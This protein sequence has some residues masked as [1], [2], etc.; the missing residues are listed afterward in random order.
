MGRVV[1]GAGPWLLTTDA[2]MLGIDPMTQRDSMMEALEIILRLFRD[3]TPGT[4]RRAG[5]PGAGQDRL[6]HP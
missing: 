1:F 3:E 2:M 4:A 6:V 5:R